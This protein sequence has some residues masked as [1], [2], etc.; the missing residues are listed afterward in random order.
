[1]DAAA[2]KAKAMRDEIKDLKKQRRLDA[3]KFRKWNKEHAG[4]ALAKEADA[5]QNTRN[6]PQALKQAR[7]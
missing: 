7:V 6:I 4:T 1:M 3:D 2:A 5:I